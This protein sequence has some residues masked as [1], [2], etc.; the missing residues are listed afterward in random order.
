V[1]GR[2]V[3]GD[4]AD[5]NAD[6]RVPTAGVIGDRSVAIGAGELLHSDSNVPAGA[7]SVGPLNP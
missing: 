6:T 4:V 1:W 5:L 3:C 2:S 7:F